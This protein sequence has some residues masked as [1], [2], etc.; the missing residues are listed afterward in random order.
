VLYLDAKL[1]P[2]H[3]N[4]LLC[5]KT[6]CF[7][8]F[9]QPLYISYKSVWDKDILLSF[10]HHQWRC[11]TCIPMSVL[12]AYITHRRSWRRHCVFKTTLFGLSKEDTITK[13]CL[14]LFTTLIQNRT[15]KNVDC[16]V[17]IFRRTVSITCESQDRQLCRKADSI[18]WFNS[19]LTCTFWWLW[20]TACK[21]VFI[22]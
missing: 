20:L 10:S 15:T 9:V 13:Q 6:R 3:T 5:C 2:H 8:F 19:I 1:G 11:L 7:S 21:Y 12:H 17:R 14:S 18:K 4:K 16:V 22:F